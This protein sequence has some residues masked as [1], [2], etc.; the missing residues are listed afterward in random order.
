MARPKKISWPVRLNEMLR[1]FLGYK[2]KRSEDRWKA[3]REWR[4]WH[5][6]PAASIH[7]RQNLTVLSLLWF[8]RAV[9]SV[10]IG[11][12]FSA[13]LNAVPRQWEFQPAWGTAEL[14]CELWKEGQQRTHEPTCVAWNEIRRRGWTPPAPRGY[15]K[16]RL[17]CMRNTLPLDGRIAGSRPAVGSFKKLNWL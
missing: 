10:T 15:W 1:I 6:E 12:W 3:F 17:G 2:I 8:V 7:S 9:E 16:R 14:F 4:R 5:L 13:V 11:K